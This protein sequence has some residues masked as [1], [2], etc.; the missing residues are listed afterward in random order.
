MIARL[1]PLLVALTFLAATLPF[2]EDHGPTADVV[3]GDYAYGEATLTGVTSLTDPFELYEARFVPSELADHDLLGWQFPGDALFPFASTL[4]AGSRR[5]F[6]AR[7]GWLHPVAG[8]HLVCLAFVA[9]LL[10]LCV[11]W[12]E[13]DIGRFAVLAA[14]L[15]LVTSPR[16]IAHAFNNLKDMPEAVLYSLAALAFYRSLSTRARRSWVYVGVFTGLALAQK[17][18]AIFLPFQ[19]LLVLAVEWFAFPKR[20]AQFD[21]SLA[22]GV[23]VSVLAGV[24]TWVAVSPWIWFEPGRILDHFGVYF[25]VSGLQE[26]ARVSLNAHWATLYTTPLPL[27]LLAPLGFFSSRATSSLKYFLA[28]WLLIVFGRLAL[29][30]M[31]N[32][33][34]VRHLLEFYPPLVLLAGLGLAALVDRLPERSRW[35]GAT[36]VAVLVIAFAPGA[37]ATL[38]THPNQIAYFNGLLG[39][40]QGMQANERRDACDYWGNTYWQATELANDHAPRGAVVVASSLPHVFRANTHRLRADLE[41]WHEGLGLHRPVC[42]LHLVRPGHKAPL[43]DAARRLGSPVATIALDGAPLHEVFV[44][45]GAPARELVEV[46]RDLATGRNAQHEFVTWMLATQT[47]ETVRAVQATIEALPSAGREATLERV[48]A[49]VPEVDRELLKRSLTYY[50]RTR[51]A[52][53]PPPGAAQSSGT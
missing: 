11:R 16:F 31:R 8:Y 42:L 4:A 34:G 50:S 47:P 23:G 19:F 52:S 13:E 29:P 46:C 38:R 36:R 6:S 40:L 12:L 26:K 18:N 48:R 7:L 15:F 17:Q 2:L 21:R 39:G 44:F 45:E 53:P 1:L 33:D 22:L 10:F 20:R 5:V 41:P 25:R 27:L 49:L 24:V 9:L 35:V 28:V 30:G 43:A 32:F 37:L 14:M 51:A 3:A